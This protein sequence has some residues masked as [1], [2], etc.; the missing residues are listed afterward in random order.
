MLARYI[1]MSELVANFI[2]CQSKNVRLIFTERYI[3]C[4]CNGMIMWKC[5]DKGNNIIFAEVLTQIYNYYVLRSNILKMHMRW[6]VLIYVVIPHNG[7]FCN[8]YKYIRCQH[9]AKLAFFN[10]IFCQ[11]YIWFRLLRFTQAYNKTIMCYL[12]YSS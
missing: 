10:F 5:E 6:Y 2:G 12:K 7:F 9:L 1:I 8:A 4:I 3:V 11:F